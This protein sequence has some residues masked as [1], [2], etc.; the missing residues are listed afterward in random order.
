MRYHYSGTVSTEMSSFLKRKEKYRNSE[1]N[2]GI[3]DSRV[4]IFRYI[5]KGVYRLFFIYFYRPYKAGHFC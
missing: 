5:Q 4:R 3:H 1:G 2:L